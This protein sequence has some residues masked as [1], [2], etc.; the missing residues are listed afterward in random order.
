MRGT[1]LLTC[2]LACS[3]PFA[4]TMTQTD[5]SGGEGYQGPY[6]YWTDT[7]WNTLLVDY[8]TI[9]GSLISSHNDIGH[10]VMEGMEEARGAAVADIDGDGYGDV[11]CSAVYCDSLLWRRNED[12]TGTAWTTHVID[13]YVN[14]PNSV[15]AADLDA[16]GDMD[17]LAAVMYWGDITWWENVDGAGTSWAEHAIDTDFGG[18]MCVGSADIDGD[19]D[20]DVLGA[21]N[22]DD[23]VAWWENED[24]AG[25]SWTDHTID[26]S[27]MGAVCVCPS[28]VDGD[29]DIDVVAVANEDDDLI[30]FEN[31]DGAGGSWTKHLVEDD[32]DF[33]AAASAGDIDSDGDEDIVGAYSSYI[34]WFE[35]ADGSGTSW[36]PHHVI[37]DYSSASWTHAANLDCD[38]DIDILGASYSGNDVNWWENMDGTGTEW[39]KHN[40]YG[41]MTEP[42]FV[43]A[44]DVNGAGGNDIVA[45]STEMEKVRWWDVSGYYPSIG[46]TSSILALQE[47][48]QQQYLDWTGVEP[49]GTDIAFL[50]RASANS[51]DMGSWS[52]T[53]T[54]PDSLTEVFEEGDIYFQYKV[55]LRYY[56]GYETPVLEDVTL[57]WEPMGAVEDGESPV[58]G[59]T[60][61][62]GPRS[63]PAWATGLL[64]FVLESDGV[65][66]LAVYDMSGRLQRSISES[67]G[68]GRHCVALDGLESGAYFV[69]M[70]CGDFSES[71][72]F[73][74]IR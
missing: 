8:E 65:V 23:D 27:C 22:L 63:N 61:L 73:V 11:V 3:V 20:L 5:W 25:T 66:E 36:V 13:D 58:P 12:G 41:Q 74:V 17:V 37:S 26:A 40:L 18:A 51:G 24:G 52:D 39:T 49:E 21:C 62:L 4:E 72:R 60:G 19:G 7:F 56:Y 1:I 16:D 46:L 10:D 44:G 32:F 54:S 69:R 35:N 48:S 45:T 38:N 68:A 70:S 9:P 67:Y 30:W 43:T 55:L 47:T 2:L 50:G 31:D 42:K 57:S 6:V 53:L 15:A 59:S 64:E 71:E 33:P 34:T 28:D 29:G 14:G